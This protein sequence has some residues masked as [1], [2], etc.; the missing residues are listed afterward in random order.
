VLILVSVVGSVLPCPS[1]GA[2]AVLPVPVLGP[3]RVVYDADMGDP[4]VLPVP[5]LGSGAG[6]F[7]FATGNRHSRVPTAHSADLLSWQAGP[8]ALPVLPDWAAAD[9]NH[10]YSWAPAVLA[11]Q[12]GFVMYI[13][14][15]EAR[16][17]QQCIGTAVASA[18]AGP[19]AGVGDGPLVCQR[20]LGGSIDPT[21]ARDPS[22]ELHLLWKSDGNSVSAPTSLWS[23]RLTADGLALT[24]LPHRLLSADLPWQGGVIEEPAAIPA[25]GGGWW[26]FYSGNAYDKPR[27]ATGVA[28]CPSLEGRCRDTSNGPYL[29]GSSLQPGQYAPG[30]LDTFHDGAGVLWAVFDTWNRPP[31]KGRFRC[32]RTMQ[33]APILGA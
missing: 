15:P 20:K 29:S 1:A 28:Y 6:Y 26:L 9:P 31:R 17:G 5:G 24:G 2:V 19:Y 4:F 21:I 10:L 25:T 18:P 32:C 8:D 22:G 14:L 13:T 30:G 23:Q 27:Y 7:A 16:G 12:H 11:T 33:L 3:S